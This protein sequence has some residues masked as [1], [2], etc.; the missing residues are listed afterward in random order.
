MPFLW[1]LV[2]IGV[3]GIITWLGGIPDPKHAGPLGD[4]RPCVPLFQ[5]CFD[6]SKGRPPKRP[7]YATAEECR[8]LVTSNLCD[9]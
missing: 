5:Y 9:P 4:E 1:Y 7:N 8:R 3:V 2:F 6:V